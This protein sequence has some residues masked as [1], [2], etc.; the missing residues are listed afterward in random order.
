MYNPG[1]IYGW[2][3]TG[4]TWVICGLY[5]GYIKRKYRGRYKGIAVSYTEMGSKLYD[6]MAASYYNQWQYKKVKIIT[7]SKPY[8]GRKSTK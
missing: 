7:H 3:Y 1:L 4:H 2:L 8:S 6:D 5:A